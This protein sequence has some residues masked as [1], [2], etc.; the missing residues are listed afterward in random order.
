MPLDTK[1]LY[2]FGPYRL[3]PVKRILV[4]EGEPVPV[5]PKAF[6]TLLALVQNSG[7]VLDK[8]E[9]MKTVW[10]DSFVE[11]GNLTVN[12]SM[13]RKA[14]GESPN[15]HRYIVTVPG[16]GYR[17]VAE[18]REL[19]DKG[20][21]ILEEH[22]RSRI[23][24]EQD[25]DTRFQ[26]LHAFAAIYRQL[27]TKWKISLG[28]LLVL[29]AVVI[30]LIWRNPLRSVPEKSSVASFVQVFSWKAEPGEE[31]SNGLC[32]V[33]HDGRLIAFS[34]KKENQQ[35]ISIKQIAGGEPIPVN[36]G[37]WN[38]TSVIWAPDNEHIAFVSDRGNQ[39][40]IWSS[41]SLG[42]E[43]K[44]LATLEN[45]G[46]SPLLKLW[47]S[48]GRRIYFERRSNLFMV[49]VDTG[50]TTPLTSFDP[51]KSYAKHFSVS[52]DEEQIAYTDSKDDQSDI[53][54]MPLRG[55]PPTQVTKDS[56]RESLLAWHPD[57]ERIVFSS[58]RQGT[59]QICVAYLDGREPVQITV[60]EI[61]HQ[62]AAV[63]SDGKIVDLTTKDESDLWTIDRE[64]GDEAELP[65]QAG[66]KLWPEASYNGDLLA[67][68]QASAR[69]K[70]LYSSILVRP[71]TGQGEQTQ[72][73]ADAFMLNW[74]P[75]NNH[76]GFLRYLDNKTDI[77]A[78]RVISGEQRQITKGG[79]IWGG[80]DLLPCN[81]A[82]TQE[83]DWSPDNTMIVYC[84]RKTGPANVWTVSVDGADDFQ[85]TA[86]TDSNLDFNCPLWS[87]DGK[88]IAFTSQTKTPI[89]GGH[90]EWSISIIENGVSEIVFNSKSA[91][92]LLGWSESGNEL[93]AASAKVDPPGAWEPT[94][95]ELFALALPTKAVQPI[96][97][98][99]S[100]YLSSLKLSQ[101]KKAIAFV[102]RTTGRDN[103]WI[104]AV[105]GGQ[106]R[107]L[108]QN[109]NPRVYLS[110]PSWLTD[111]KTIVFSKQTTWN[112]I[113]T[114]NN[115]K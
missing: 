98:L 49:N 18:V 38:D 27:G 80:F 24:I 60:G 113:S 9:L 4:K 82:Q 34:S 50:V 86:N 85:I 33:S 75:D 91:L 68:H 5:T 97:S 26:A 13:L 93:I 96:A 65:A 108:T 48:D 14:L 16:R 105:T 30:G 12:I 45:V 52:L 90:N 112:L 32:A 29:V 58:K 17:F 35:S 1:H 7:D 95:I 59:Y 74:S 21:L 47:S 83:F 71:I 67:F 56:A 89:E 36:A 31:I 6:D 84:S 104:T 66:V 15:Q 51:S 72:I 28:T 81:R 2:E 3:D 100:T 94:D 115:F 11:E 92:R 103:L 37:K 55:G 44:L 77:W 57:G 99:K 61:D 40:G 10:P 23:L 42:G 46:F 53:W 63:S 70:A 22:T 106:L 87:S 79:V 39:V 43:V 20:D 64:T 76:I 102:S 73:A 107:S 109:T 78:V 69:G 101:N 110:S 19:L 111:A 54:I 25:T 41:L 62:V 8:D 88:R 114:I